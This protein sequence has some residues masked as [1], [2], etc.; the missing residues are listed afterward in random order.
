MQPA[1]SLNYLPG[2]IH[3]L[4]TPLAPTTPLPDVPPAANRFRRE[5]VVLEGEDQDGRHESEPPF[6]APSVAE[7]LKVWELHQLQL[8]QKV[9]VDDVMSKQATYGTMTPAQRLAEFNGIRGA[10]VSL[11]LN[12]IADLLR[13]ST[14][15]LLKLY[16]DTTNSLSRRAVEMAMH[17]EDA[18]AAIKMLLSFIP[19]RYIES[20]GAQALS[21]VGRATEMLTRTAQGFWNVRD[22]KAEG[23]VNG[24]HTFYG[25]E[26]AGGFATTNFGFD[27]AALAPEP[28]PTPITPLSPCEPS[29]AS[30]SGDAEDV[31]AAEALAEDALL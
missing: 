10:H 24:V 30:A 12:G 5:R 23:A 22:P 14:L 7:L 18:N 19:E 28:P 15:G 3:V 20:G 6:K 2:Q 11:R 25:A 27:P 26:K 9:T 31:A 17:N 29:D 21:V 13:I 16:P 4:R 1:T 8:G